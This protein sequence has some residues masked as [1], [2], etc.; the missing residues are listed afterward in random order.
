MSNAIRHTPSGGEVCVR[1]FRRGPDGDLVVEVRDTGEGISA[2]QLPYVFDRFWRAEK[3][4]N[5][6][7][8]GSGLGLAIVRRLMEAHGGTVDVS[9]VVGVGTV[10]TLWFPMAARWDRATGPD[11][12]GRGVP[13]DG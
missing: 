4:R 13:A 12:D 9:S 8:G 2:E 3:S 1:A 10:F 6:R 7:T 11:T 5:R